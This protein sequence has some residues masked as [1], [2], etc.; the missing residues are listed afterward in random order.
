[1]VKWQAP[2]ANDPRNHNSNRR[3]KKQG[4]TR[5]ASF[6]SQ[7]PETGMKAMSDT[8]ERTIAQKREQEGL[9]KKFNSSHITLKVQKQTKRK[10]TKETKKA[11]QGVV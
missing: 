7:T 11:A 8:L 9:S 1:M 10:G 5:R 4:D 3:A 2:R 6:K